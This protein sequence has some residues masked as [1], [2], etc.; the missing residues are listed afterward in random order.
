MGSREGVTAHGH[1]TLGLFLALAIGGARVLLI[2]ADM[3][4][5]SVHKAMRLP[6][7]R[8]LAELLNGKSR[9]REVSRRSRQ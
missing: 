7:D 9:M 3:R 4:R 5:P 2:D 6:N 1:G 8:G